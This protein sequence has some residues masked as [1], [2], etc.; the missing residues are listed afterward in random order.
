ME[1]A[2]NQY[3]IYNT[4]QQTAFCKKQYPK[5]QLRNLGFFEKLR[6]DKESNHY[7]ST[8]KYIL[9]YFAISGTMIAKNP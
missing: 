1:A 5:K 8:I 2:A 6:G 7:I 4:S 3:S 9:Q